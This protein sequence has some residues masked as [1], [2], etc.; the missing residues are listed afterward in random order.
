MIATPVGSSGERASTSRTSRALIALPLIAL[1][2]AIP[3]LVPAWRPEAPEPPPGSVG[4]LGFSFNAR[5]VAVPSGRYPVGSNLW[6]HDG[7]WWGVLFRPNRDAHVV[8]RY[9]PETTTWT[10]TGT[11]IDDRNA[12]RVDVLWDGGH[13][14]A[15]SGGQDPGDSDDAASLARLSYDSLSGQY[16]MDRG[17]PVRV[18]P[19]GAEAFT[20]DR[21]DTGRLWATWTYDGKV[22]VRHSLADDR[23]WSELIALP[24]PQAENLSPDDVS[25]VVAYDGHVGV[26]WSNR[27]AGAMYW[28]SLPAGQAGD[29]GWTVTAALQG[30]SL[31]DSRIDLLALRD[32][33]A[34]EVVAAVKTGR[35]NL[36]NPGKDDPAVFVMVL[37]ANESWARYVE[38]TVGDDQGSP[39]LALDRGR[40][41]LHVF[42]SGPCCD[43]GVIYRKETPLDAISFEPGPGTAFISRGRG[44]ALDGPT[45]A[46]HVMTSDTGLL[47]VASDAK[48]GVYMQNLLPLTGVPVAAPSTPSPSGASGQP[49]EGEPWL[50]D[51]FETGTLELWPIVKTGPSSTAAADPDHARTDAYGAHLAAGSAEGAFAFARH[52]LARSPSR[53]ELAMDFRVLAEGAAN[54]NV[55]LVR[56]LDS[57]GSRIVSVYRQNQ[58]RGGI[59]I[60]TPDARTETLGWVDLDTWSRLELSVADGSGGVVVDVRLDGQFIGRSLVD[61]GAGVAWVQIGNEVKGQRFDIAIDNVMIGP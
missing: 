57:D 30:P 14:Y 7:A 28:A 13:L 40:R 43:G 60:A 55:P 61:V 50:E 46:K 49:S 47:V 23:T 6:F 51:G 38:S 44:S 11:V 5:A 4:S 41:T 22:W 29:D 31:A 34:G 42:T 56:L 59:W 9:D 53:L 8:N 37:S 48:A 12:A 25:A 3:S 20:L 16:S 45:T 10:D 32:D 18:A 33:P 2:L 39:L 15:L 17:F 19:S 36:V 58:G 35:G 52:P 27:T 21:D 24:V 26:M 1:L 54:S